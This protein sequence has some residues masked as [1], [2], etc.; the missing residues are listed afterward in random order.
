MTGM[1]N[2]R[3]KPDDT[4]DPIRAIARWESEGGALQTS[5][6]SI[7]SGLNLT[8]NSGAP[9]QKV[10]QKI[11]AMKR[12]YRGDRLPPPWTSRVELNCSIRITRA[13]RL[14]LSTFF[15]NPVAS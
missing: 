11:S 4:Y 9:E 15:A 12:I 7:R 8:A 10:K 5:R 14:F 3:Q 1:T 2:Q 6:S 13:D